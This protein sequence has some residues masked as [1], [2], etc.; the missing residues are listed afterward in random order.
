VGSSISNI[1]AL[2]MKEILGTILVGGLIACPIAWFLMDKWLSDYA[3]RIS[4]TPAPFIAAIVALGLIT[5]VL[6]VMQ[7][8]KTALM[9]PVH[10]LRSE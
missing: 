4:I 5:A 6:V 9:N 1:I 8:I 10:S 3:N 7:T 2:F